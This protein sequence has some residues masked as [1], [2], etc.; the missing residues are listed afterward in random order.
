M[1]NHLHHLP[2]ALEVIAHTD[3]KKEGAMA[4]AVAA[5]TGIPAALAVAGLALTPVGWI[6]ALGAGAA[7]GASYVSRKRK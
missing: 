5:G 4:G 1:S 7:A 2:H 3:S 6:L